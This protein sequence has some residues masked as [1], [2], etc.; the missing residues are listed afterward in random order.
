MSL[1]MMPRLPNAACR[2]PEGA[3]LFLNVGNSTIAACKAICAGCPDK[4]ACLRW[5]LE[6]E[7][8]WGVWG[9]HTA[10]ELEYLRQLYGVEV[11]VLR[12]GIYASD[13]GHAPHSSRRNFDAANAARLGAAVVSAPKPE[14]VAEAARGAVAVAPPR[15]RVTR[16]VQL[17]GA[18]TPPVAR[19]PLR[20]LVSPADARPPA[21]V[22]PPPDDGPGTPAWEA[23]ATSPTVR[24]WALRDGW[25]IRPDAERVPG[26]IVLAYRNAHPGETP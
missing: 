21:P 10:G 13:N 9:G 22:P 19:Q 3:E 17:P 4:G 16:L 6:H 20:E 26:A 7:A 23:L 12:A 11:K 8:Q 14:C 25:H 2:T 15:R 18:H 5:G 1:D 24:D